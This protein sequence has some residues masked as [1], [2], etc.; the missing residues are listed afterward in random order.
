MKVPKNQNIITLTFFYIKFF[1]LD[2][3]VFQ[4]FSILSD[5]FP[6]FT[7][8]LILYIKKN[9]Y[10]SG[11]SFF[12]KFWSGGVPAS[13]SSLLFPSSL[14]LSSHVDLVSLLC[15]DLCSYLLIRNDNETTTSCVHLSFIYWY[16]LIITRL[17]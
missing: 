15:C 2:Y 14:L 8:K 16:L 9:Y 13:I 1:S 5:S 12:K 17:A 3:L 4:F 7:S 6:L 10:F 11:I